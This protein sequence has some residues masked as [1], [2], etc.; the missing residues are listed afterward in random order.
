MSFA[1][2][3]GTL[4]ARLAQLS[5]LL[6]QAQGICR[7]LEEQA[8]GLAGHTETLADDAAVAQIGAT[9]RRARQDL[10]AMLRA[11]DGTRSQSNS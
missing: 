8:E 11:I 6:R 9:A 2:Q 3:R 4:T 7:S 1:E 5:E 10:G